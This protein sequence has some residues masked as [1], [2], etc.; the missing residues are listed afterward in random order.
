[1]NMSAQVRKRIQVRGTVQG[2]GFRPFVFK[3]AS[4]LQISGF[5]RNTETGVEIEAEGAAVDDFLAALR[6]EAPALA[7]IAEI[8]VSDLERL[9][10]KGFRD[11]GKR[12]ADGRFRARTAGYRDLYRVFS[13]YDNTRQSPLPLPIYKLHQLRC[14]LHDY[15]GHPIRP[16]GYY[17]VGVSDVHRLRGGIPQ[18]QRSAI[19]CPAQCLPSLRAADFGVCRRSSSLADD[20]AGS[21]HQGAWGLPLGLRCRERRGCPQASRTQRARR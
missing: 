13:R 12:P 2:V 5:V 8:D 21:C 17:D 10:E 3:L 19:P 4:R 6:V 15:S 1:M 16:P 14:S 9:S 11:S 7:R 20:G 18:S